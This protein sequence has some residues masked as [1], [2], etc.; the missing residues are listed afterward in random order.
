MGLFPGLA[1]GAPANELVIPA[2]RRELFALFAGMRASRRH[3]G[4]RAYLKPPPSVQRASTTHYSRRGWRRGGAG[5]RRGRVNR[6]P[7]IKC[8]CKYAPRS[9]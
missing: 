2:L 5:R 9:A 6:G 8:N 1:R 4:R 3:K 7:L